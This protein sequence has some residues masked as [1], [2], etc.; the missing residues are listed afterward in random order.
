MALDHAASWRYCPVS[1]TTASLIR[2]PP[3]SRIALRAFSMQEARG[4]CHTTEEFHDSRSEDCGVRRCP[5]LSGLRRLRRGSI[6]AGTRLG[7]HKLAERGEPRSDWT[8]S[9][10]GLCCSTSGSSPGELHPDRTLTGGL[11]STVPPSGPYP[12][13]HSHPRVPAL[14]RRALPGRTWP[15]HWLSTA[16]A[17][18]M[19]RT[20]TVAP[21]IA[22]GYAT[23]PASR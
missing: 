5:V 15:W 17:I 14:C 21:G 3:R 11:R 19:P 13:R 16:S 10:A 6:Q 8:S 12:H 4:R 9:G 18:P 7:Q 20:M 2:F 23:G 1:G 22:T